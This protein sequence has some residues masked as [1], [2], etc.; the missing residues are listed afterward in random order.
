MVEWERLG[1]LRGIAK[2]HGTKDTT[3]TKGEG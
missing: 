3:P 2:I 1:G